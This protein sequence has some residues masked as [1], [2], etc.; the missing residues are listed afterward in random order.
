MSDVK[1]DSRGL[2]ESCPWETTLFNSNRNGIFCGKD[3]TE[4]TGE[5]F[6]CGV[7]RFQ[8]DVVEKYSLILSITRLY[9]LLDLKDGCFFLRKIERWNL[10]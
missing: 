5:C 7:P 9:R 10:L 6:Y 2:Q 3:I 1:S 4:I 8:K